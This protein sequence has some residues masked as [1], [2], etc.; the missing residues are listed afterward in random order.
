MI[1]G[2]LLCLTYINDLSDN[3]N[4]NAKLFAGDSPF[5][6][7]G[8]YL[9]FLLALE[10]KGSP[11]REKLRECHGFWLLCPTGGKTIV[12]FRRV[13]PTLFVSEVSLI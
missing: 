2:S 13:S 11:L 12:S 4:S 10:Q 6:S 9:F 7:V 5:F 8:Q 1:V 3:L